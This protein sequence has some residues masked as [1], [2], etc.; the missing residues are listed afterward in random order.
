MKK[1]ENK[2]INSGLPELRA[3]YAVWRSKEYAGTSRFVPQF[4]SALANYF[5]SGMRAIAVS[6]GT[7]AIEVAIKALGLKTGSEVML[8]AYAPVM[9]VIP[10]IHA[11]MVPVFVDSEEESLNIDIEDVRRKYTTRTKALMVVPM[12]GYPIKMKELSQFCTQK[13]MQLIE[14]ASHCHGSKSGSR[15]VGTL[16]DI[17]TFSTQERKMIATGEGGFILTKSTS[18]EAKVRSVRDFGKVQEKDTRFPDHIGEYGFYDGSNFRISGPSAALGTAQVSKLEKKIA[19]RTSNARKIAS[20]LQNTAGFEELEN[21]INTRN[22]YYSIVFKLS[23][24]DA[25]SLGAYLAERGIISDTFRFK[26]KPLYKM[27]QFKR[28]AAPCPHTEAFLKNIITLPTHEG[29]RSSDIDLIVRA[30]IEFAAKS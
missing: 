8:P 9:S 29:L 13:K 21:T 23:G 10:I 25:E 30:L 28:Y 27:H 5:G 26:I 14:D 22:N 19:Q 16:S 24:I 17:A 18:I 3:L 7:D 15:F 6:N 12:W 1:L 20:A 2:Y 11:G 4:E